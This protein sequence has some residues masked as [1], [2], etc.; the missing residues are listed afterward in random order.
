MRRERKIK[1]WQNYVHPVIDCYAPIQDIC[2][3]KTSRLK[4]RKALW[5]DISWE[6][7]AYDPAVYEK[8]LSIISQQEKEIWNRIIFITQLLEGL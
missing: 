2:M 6:R 7:L 3:K 5:I 8:F 1:G 4:M